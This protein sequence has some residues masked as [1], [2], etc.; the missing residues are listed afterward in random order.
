MPSDWTETARYVVAHVSAVPHQFAHGIGQQQGY[1]FFL[2]FVAAVVAFS[3]YP[4]V[5]QNV[6]LAL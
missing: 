3:G 4:Y 5:T 2:G 6:A 1:K